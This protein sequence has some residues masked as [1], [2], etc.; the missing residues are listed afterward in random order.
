M[1][2]TRR[3]FLKTSALTGATVAIGGLGIFNPARA[4]AY[5][6]TPPLIHKFTIPLPGL[7]PTGIP[8]ATPIR[9]YWWRNADYYKI[10]VRQFK[11]VFHPDFYSIY[12]ANFPGSTLWG[13]ASENTADFVGGK[14]N[15]RYLGGLIIAN[16]GRPV[17]LQVKNNLVNQ[18]GAP[19]LHPVAVDPTVMDPLVIPPQQ[20]AME[21]RIGVHLHGGLVPWISDG[22]PF[23]W[24]NP[25]GVT[26]PSYFNVPDMP[27]P[28][29]GAMTFY[30]PNDQSARLMWY[31]DH[32]Y[33]LTRLNAYVGLATGY[34]ITDQVEAGLLRLGIIP[35]MNHLAPLILQDKSFVPLGG[36]TQPEGRGNPGDLWYPSVYEGY[37]PGD[38]VFESCAPF[39]PIV[40]SGKARWELNGGPP[41]GPSA[42]PEFF[43]DT[44]VI[45]GACY[46]FLDV[47]QR[48]YRFLILNGS[49]ARFFN[50]QLYYADPQNPTEIPVIP[51]N[52]ICG[53]WLVPDLTKVKPGPSIIQIGNEGGFLPYAVKLNNPP[54]PF[55]AQLDANGVIP[56]TMTYTLLLGPAERADIIID[57]SKCPVGSKLIL[58]NDA[59]APFPNGDPRD[60][61]YTGAPDY[62]PA[63]GAPTP[64]PGFGPNTRTLMQFRVKARTGKADPPQMNLLE[65]AALQGLGGPFGP[66]TAANVFPPIAP[67]V[68]SGPPRQLALWETFD[69]YGR[70][71]Q[72]L[73]NLTAPSP[74]T[75]NAGEVVAAGSTEVW[76]IY[77]TTG[78]THPMHF[79]LVNVQVIGRAQFNPADYSIITP[80]RS[81][82]NNE[83]GWKETVRMNPGEVI[84]VIM[85]FEL[86]RTPFPVPFSPR[87]KALPPPY[88]INAYE[89]VWHCHILEHE[90][91]DMMHALSVVP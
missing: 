23:S 49:Q 75:D 37:P 81:P 53:N 86:P 13:Y 85:K 80:F 6:Q 8:V 12:G 88:A 19:L 30:Y 4:Y 20:A 83:R 45:N 1:S 50:L 25:T 70:L 68:P 29:P 26:G 22:G 52:T 11:Q 51:D 89:Y 14:P 90:E 18:F 56:S 35:D 69:A 16:R 63:G 10:A 87:L 34:L 40:P 57:F 60:D 24:F 61:Y 28:P 43:G 78:D 3:Q 66:T 91:H 39:A 46:P 41:P 27:A 17:R 72:M 9:Q 59:P 67:L 42:I 48:H 74:Y 31:H 5:L 47:E 33:G 54:A 58:Y 55:T 21:N 84:R 77:N 36:N 73:G 7:G 44:T 71:Q 65:K 76:E 64:N 15:H 62:T 32:A 38:P 2:Y 82:D 79:H